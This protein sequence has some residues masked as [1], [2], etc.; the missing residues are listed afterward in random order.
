MSMTQPSRAEIIGQRI[1]SARKRQGM[2]QVQLSEAIAARSGMEPE[3]VRRSLVNN[4]TGKH[5]PRLQTLEVIAEITEQP[6][7]FFVGAP[8]V[9]PD[10]EF[11]SEAAA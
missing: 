10:G 1:R 4:E 8:E 2:S 11:P 5:A 9:E 6:L 3:T 7:E